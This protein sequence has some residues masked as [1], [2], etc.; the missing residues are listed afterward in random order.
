[1]CPFLPVA[2]LREQIPSHWVST[3]NVAI[4][5]SRKV[6]WDVFCEMDPLFALGSTKRWNFHRLKVFRDSCNHV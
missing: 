1:M 3:F 2:L 5:F 4:G 6:P